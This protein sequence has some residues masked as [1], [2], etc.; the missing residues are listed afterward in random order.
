[1]IVL[2]TGLPGT[3]KTTL[4]R[5]LAARTSGRVLS[6]DE[7]RHA[8]HNYERS[9]LKEKPVIPRLLCLGERVRAKE[10]ALTLEIVIDHAQEILQV[11][12]VGGTESRTLRMSEE[13]LIP[14]GMFEPN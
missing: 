2:M 5:E 1:M 9:L 10:G 4:A 13:G 3:G 11:T 7:I 6:K 8:R 14:F 12:H